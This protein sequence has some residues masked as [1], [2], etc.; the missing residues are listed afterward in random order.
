MPNNS[1]LNKKLRCRRKAARCSVV[2]NFAKSLKV[3]QSLHHSKDHVLLFALHSDCNVR[4]R[5][6]LTTY[7]LCCTIVITVSV[8]DL[9]LD[10]VSSC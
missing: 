9:I 6:Y 5:R 7:L 4:Q 2:K 3:V 1:A 8:S 10:K